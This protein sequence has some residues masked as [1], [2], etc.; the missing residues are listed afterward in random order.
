MYKNPDSARDGVASYSSAR[1]KP[2]L[3][4]LAEDNTQQQARHTTERAVRTQ[5]PFL[6]INSCLRL[7]INQDRV[8]RRGHRPTIHRHFPGPHLSSL[9]LHGGSKHKLAAPHAELRR[10]V[11]VANDA[12]CDGGV[13][14]RS[15]YPVRRK[16][17]G[18]GSHRH[19]A[20]NPSLR[21]VRQERLHHGAVS[22]DSAER[23][24][25]HALLLLL[26]TVYAG[27]VAVDEELLLL[28]VAAGGGGSPVVVVVGVVHVDPARGKVAVVAGVAASK[29]GGGG[30]TVAVPG[31]S[32]HHHHRLLVLLL[33]GVN[34]VVLLAH[35]RGVVRRTLLLLVLLR[36]ARWPAQAARPGGWALVLLLLVRTVGATGRPGTLMFNVGNT[37][38]AYR[39]KTEG[40][41]L[42][43]YRREQKQGV[44]GAVS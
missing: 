12:A 9:H 41:L 17:R 11:A 31:V 37:Q 20:P 36:V 3:L 24:R 21:L 25:T 44:S 7:P 5:P 34:V 10:G 1:N 40:E 6:A 27:G 32:A 26:R 42:G 4:F 13:R 22:V 18:G 28:S 30:M 29:A 38:Q 8:A 2:T 35:V 23:G 14:R 16:R 33:L 39:K 19:A 43:E 15:H